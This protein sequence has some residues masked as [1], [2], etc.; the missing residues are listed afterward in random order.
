MQITYTTWYK[1]PNQWF[2]RKVK[3]CTGWAHYDKDDKFEIH[4]E[5]GSILFP[6]YKKTKFKFSKE[7]IAFLKQ[8]MKKEGMPG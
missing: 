8:N 5:K 7:Y 2:W 1:M 4:Y 6:E 3:N